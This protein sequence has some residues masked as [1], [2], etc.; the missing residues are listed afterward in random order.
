MMVLLNNQGEVI[1]NVAH[2]I[3]N[4]SLSATPAINT[5]S[6]RIVHIGQIDHKEKPSLKHSA[7]GKPFDTK[8]IL[9]TSLLTKQVST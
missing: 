4:K 5:T 7:L 2:T 6:I 9:I 1:I 8:Q 3:Y